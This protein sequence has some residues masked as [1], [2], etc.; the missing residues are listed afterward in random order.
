ME[1]TDKL[2]IDQL[3]ALFSKNALLQ[4]YLQDSSEVK[5]EFHKAVKKQKWSEAEDKKNK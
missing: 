3:E 5:S 1:E 4:S 2:K